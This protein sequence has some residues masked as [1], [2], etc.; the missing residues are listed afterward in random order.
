MSGEPK[1]LSESLLKAKLSEG[2]GKPV[3][4]SMT[5]V[6]VIASEW[7]VSQETETKVDKK[8]K[9][10]QG[11][12]LN[13]TFQMKDTESPFYESYGGLRIYEKDEMWIGT[14]SA[15]GKLKKTIEDFTGLKVDTPQDYN[16]ALLGKLVSVKTV[17]QNVGG[18]D[19][20]KIEIKA[21]Y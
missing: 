11:A 2:T 1:Q 4:E 21:I 10:Y 14:K 5:K 19:Y 7:L 8:N 15:L 9:E 3:F 6:V 12:Y 18:T 16:Q 13:L 20:D 17:T